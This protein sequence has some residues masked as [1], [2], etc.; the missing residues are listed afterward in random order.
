MSRPPLL[1]ACWGLAA[2]TGPHAHDLRSDER[3]DPNTTET[4]TQPLV[5]VAPHEFSPAAARYVH[6]CHAHGT[7]I[8]SSTIM[9]AL[10][11]MDWGKPAEL[12]EVA[13]PEPGPGEVLLKVGGA[14]ACHSDL[15]LMDWPGGTLQWRVP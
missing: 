1:R 15:H 7:S 4:E 11:L 10:R 6:L 3:S 9:R 2:K 8:A 14:G 5:R 13:V 12:C